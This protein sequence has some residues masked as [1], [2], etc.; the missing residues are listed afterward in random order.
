[1]DRCPEVGQDRGATGRIFGHPPVAQAFENHHLCTCT[2]GPARKATTAAMSSGVP[3]RPAGADA[4]IRSK[5]PGAM[6]RATGPV[7]SRKPAAIAPESTAFAVM[8]RAPSSLARTRVATS[9][10]ALDVA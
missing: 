2:A 1:M 9:G 4:A 6:L 8:P 7:K 5:V 10:P 3:N